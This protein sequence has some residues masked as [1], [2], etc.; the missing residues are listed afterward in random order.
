MSE[1]LTKIMRNR[2][3]RGYATERALVKLLQNEGYKAVRIPVSN[4]SLNPLPDVFASKDKNIYAFEVKAAKRYTYTPQ[5]QIEKLF[6]F[7]NMIPIEENHKHAIVVGHFSKQWR[8]KEIKRLK[9]QVRLRKIDK[10]NW[11]P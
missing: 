4:T 1:S 10:G 6:E 11:N 7:L 2:R 5:R 9:G 3:E 8:Y